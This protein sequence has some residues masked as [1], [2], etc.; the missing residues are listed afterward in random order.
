[1]QNTTSKNLARWQVKSVYL[2]TYSEADL[3]LFP[4]RESFATAIENAFSSSQTDLL[5]WVCCLENHSQVGVHYHMAVKLNR[6]QRW[7][8]VKDKLKSEFGV[9]VNFS[10][11]HANYYGAWRY[12]TKED[13]HYI[14]SPDHPDLANNAGP[15]TMSALQSVNKVRK[16]KQRWPKVGKE[17]KVKRLT[18]FDISEL[19]LEKKITS[20]LQLLAMEN[21]QKTAGKTDLTQFVL[22]NNEKKLNDIINTT[23]EMHNAQ[24]TLNRKSK[25]RMGILAEFLSRDYCDD[26]NGIWLTS[27]KEVLDNNNIPVKLFSS[28]VKELLTQGRGKYKN[29]MIVAPANCAKTS[30]Y[31]RSLLYFNVLLIQPLQ[32]LRG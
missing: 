27:A 12:V 7:L 11:N 13:K 14:E 19:I 31:F 21:T 29:V 28:A 32:R 15:R 20:R 1:M 4:T 22:N 30:Y 25:S 17:N 16:R 3:Q 2:I 18:N 5:H 8:W 9:A 10:A 23:W 26:C 24:E 6:N